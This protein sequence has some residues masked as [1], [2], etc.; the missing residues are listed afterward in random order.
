[1]RVTTGTSIG[2][3][4]S[5]DPDPL[6]DPDRQAAAAAVRDKFLRLAYQRMDFAVDDEPLGQPVEYPSPN[7]ASLAG[8]NGRAAHAA[9]QGVRD[10]LHDR[11]AGS[12]KSTNKWS[13][14]R[15]DPFMPV[16]QRLDLSELRELLNDDPALGRR[17]ELAGLS[18]NAWAGHSRNCGALCRAV[19]DYLGDGFRSVQTARVELRPEHVMVVVGSFDPALAHRPMS[20]W[21]PHLHVCDPWANIA[22]PAPEYPRRFQDKMRKWEADGKRLLITGTTGWQSPTLHAWLRCPERIERVLIGQRYRSGQSTSKV[23]QVAGREEGGGRRAGGPLAVA[24]PARPGLGR[25]PTTPG[26][27]S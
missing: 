25:G 24:L 7:E 27:I 8:T 9:L 2:P 1:M 26:D 20:D 17:F 23:I 19:E 6:I 15:A 18:A 11:A 4:S 5:I 10:A 14:G 16:E 22:C 13:A 12:A 3:Q 21:P